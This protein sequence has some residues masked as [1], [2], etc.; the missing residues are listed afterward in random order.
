MVCRWERRQRFPF[1]PIYRRK[2]G[3]CEVNIRIGDSSPGFNGRRAVLPDERDV[4]FD[5]PEE[6][7]KWLNQP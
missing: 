3:R 6:T 2:Q 1:I 7:E 4:P 5:A